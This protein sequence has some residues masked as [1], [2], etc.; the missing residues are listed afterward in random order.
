M[1]RGG[2]NDESLEL[3]TLGG[4]CYWCLE[5]VFELLEGVESVVSGAA[6]GPDPL[7]MPLEKL[8]LGNSLVPDLPLAGLKEGESFQVNMFD[9]IFFTSRPVD[10]EV[11]SLDT[12]K[13]DGL[14]VDVYTLESTFRGF[15][16]T[17][18][19]TRDG[20]VLRIHLERPFKGV[21]LRHEKSAATAR[22]GISE[23][24]ATD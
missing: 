22:R 5:A 9:P 13:I 10:V 15:K 1:H 8:T 7:S 24:R 17:T 18:L 3:V 14:L 20:T 21:K 11:V 12:Q 23:K 4:G 19:V 16:S 2:V 6:G